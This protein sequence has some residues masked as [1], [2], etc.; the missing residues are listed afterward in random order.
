MATD[1]YDLHTIDYSVQGWDA[2]MATD[3]EKIDAMI[4]TRILGTL[5]EAVSAY[6]ALYLKISDQKW[7]KALADG[8]KQPCLGLAVEGG[9]LNDVIRIHRMGEIT[10]AAWSWG[11]GPI[12]LSGSVTGELTESKPAS[13][14][15]L[16]GYGLSLTKMLVMIESGLATG[17]E[18]TLSRGGTILTP[19]EAINIIVWR[20][21]FACE[22]TK[23]WGYR[24]GGTGATINARRNGADNHLSSALS[25]TS[26]DTWMDGGAVQ[27]TA[28]MA[29]D[30]LEIMVVSVAGAPGQVAVQVDFEITEAPPGS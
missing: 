6:Q 22:V 10:N 15:Q 4:P 16:V 23:V 27:N 13:N 14:A 5:G 9:V 29:G 19:T 11:G 21:P 26:A 12:Y 18:S 20:G 2:I 8:I 17:G 30:K 1:K 25:L 3:M 24:V 7:Y 28:Y